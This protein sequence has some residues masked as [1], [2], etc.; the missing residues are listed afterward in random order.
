[1]AGFRLSESLESDLLIRRAKADPTDAIIEAVSHIREQYYGHPDYTQLTDEAISH[2]MRQLDPYSVYLAEEVDERFDQYISGTYEGLGFEYYQTPDTLVITAVY[3]D[4]PVDKAGLRR[5]D[6]L[7]SMDGVRVTGF[8]LTRDSIT[9]L[10]S[11]PVGD[12][13]RMKW[14]G[15]QTKMIHEAN[16]VVGRV[17]SPLVE[18]FLLPDS[19]TLLV[20]IRRFSNGTFASFM[21]SFDR[22]GMIGASVNGLII[23]VRDNPGGILS[24]TVKILNQ[25][26][27]QPD[28]LL[29]STKDARGKI[30]SFRSNGRGFLRI[31]DIAVLINENSASASEILAGAL[32]DHDRAIIVGKP[33]YGK[34]LI[35]QK[36]DLSNRGA[37]NLTVGEYVLPSGRSINRT[38]ETLPDSI[39]YSV[40]LKRKLPSHN[41]ISPDV[42]LKGDSCL[43]R[44][45][46]LFN[47]LLTAPGGSAMMLSSILSDPL[48]E[49][50]SVQVIEKALGDQIDRDGCEKV[51][52]RKLMWSLWRSQH[53]GGGIPPADVLD[54][55]VWEVYQ[56]F[57]PKDNQSVL[58]AIL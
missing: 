55:W 33:S 4:S 54:P 31:E 37:I 44:K 49:N 26:I 15:F 35:Q 12:T 17:N 22:Y 42:E 19:S 39:R 27:E 10:S 14:Y 34:G 36:Y 46:D 18:A 9:Q 8:A 28:V 1:M 6:I 56:L 47:L 24:E 58:D 52:Q 16:V 13:I 5:G 30:R 53:P 51:L 57:S 11:K 43:W 20:S 21:E 29:A 3:N 41:G 7:L 45:S 2:I 32:Q 48:K 50:G 40:R 38:D 23:D 25:L